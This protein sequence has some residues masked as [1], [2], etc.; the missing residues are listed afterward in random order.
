M[1]VTTEEV[2]AECPKCHEPLVVSYPDTWCRS[3]GESLPDDILRVLPAVQR[4]LADDRLILVFNCSKCQKPLSSQE[5]R[6]EGCRSFQSPAFARILPFLLLAVAMVGL[7]G[8]VVGGIKTN[9]LP[10]ALSVTVPVFLVLGVTAYGL[11]RGKAWGWHLWTIVLGG[12][13]LGAVA[14]LIMLSRE[15]SMAGVSAGIFF[16]TSAIYVGVA[17]RTARQRLWNIATAIYSGINAALILWL[18]IVQVAKQTTEAGSAIFAAGFTVT[19]GL[20]TVLSYSLRFRWWY[21]IRL[22]WSGKRLDSPEDRIRR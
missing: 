7:T 9:E 5:H 6:C 21:R 20:L 8:A 17:W 22:G 18:V 14:M 1:N 12:A 19:I 4:A 13:M 15:N 10:Q 16:W 3:C 11:F 2:I